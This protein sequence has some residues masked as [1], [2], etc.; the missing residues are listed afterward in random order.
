M[1]AFIP[2]PPTPLVGREAEVRSILELLHH[3]QIHLLT[4]CGP[5]GVGKT[6][7]ALQIAT[8]LASEFGDRVYWCD[9]AAL[10]DSS[11]VPQ[12]VA[13][14][15]GIGDQPNR[16]AINAICDFIQSRLALL[17]LDNCEHLLEACAALVAVISD[18]CPN[19]KI[20]TT[21]LQPLDLPQE[22]VWQVPPLTLPATNAD[23]ATIG[24][25]DA[26]RLF[27]ERAR[28]VLPTFTLDEHNAPVIAA[29]CRRLDGLPLAIE[30]AAARVK[31]LSPAQI[32]ERLDDAF[33]LLT[34]GKT[35]ALPRHQTL[36]ATMDWSYALLTPDE[37]VLTRRLSVFAGSFTVEMVEAIN[38]DESIRIPLLDVL[39][40]LVDKSLVAIYARD[41]QGVVRFRML[42]TIRQYA[43]EKLEASGETAAVR[44]RLLEWAV[45]FAEALQPQLTGREASA[46]LARL[47]MDEDN[48]R[49]A[50]QWA[51]LKRDAERGLRLATALWVYW[52]NRGAL[53]E[54][55]HWLDE[56][57]AMETPTPVLPMVRA[58][59]L[60]AAGR[61]AFRQS[62]L[63]RAHE[64]SEASLKAAHAANDPVSLAAA[65][66]LL[67]I[68][69]TERGDVSRAV[70]MHE[71]A[72]AIHRQLNDPNRAA[73]TLINLGILERRRGE[74]QRAAALYE[75]ALTI[76][77]QFGDQSLTAL[78]LLNLGETAVWQ[79]EYARAALWLEE[80]LHLYRQLENRTQ[81]ATALLN[82]SAVARYQGER[83]RARAF[84]EEAI[85][86]HQAVGDPIRVN[87]ARINLGDL[88]RDEGDWVR[89]QSLYADA[90]AHLRPVGDAW[91]IALALYSLG[92][93]ASHQHDEVQARKYYLES[94]QLYHRVGFLI[95]IGMIEVLEALCELD[96]RQGDYRRA[97]RG[98]GVAAAQRARSGAPIP[99]TE[100]ARDEQMREAIRAAL[101][102]RTDAAIQAEA[103]TLTV[104]QV[105]MEIVGAEQPK[106][107]PVATPEPVVKIYALGATRVVVGDR[108]LQ[109]TDWKYTKAR[110]LFFYLLCNPPA[111]KA[112]IGLE[113]W[114]DASP[115][116]VRNYFH[117]ALHYV[118]KA[119]GRPDWI[120]FTG[121]TYTF[122]HNLPHWC[123]IVAYDARLAEAQALLQSGLPPPAQ[124]ARALQLL[125]EAVQL[126][127]GD[128]LAD[129]DAGEWAI[130]RRE[131][132]HQSLLQALL[133][134]GRL[135]LAEA[136]YAEAARSF[137]RALTFDNYL[138]IAHRELMRTYAR[139]GDVAR[140]MRHFD[141]VRRMMRAEFGADPSAETFLLYD[142]LRRGDDV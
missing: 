115:K 77:R 18:T 32:A 104:E 79:G 68:L 107:T 4:L 48:L 96:A 59:A 101:G 127:H 37:Q 46:A 142:R 40:G 126:Q 20:L 133:D 132:L 42:E 121:D 92:L 49:A 39:T 11:Y 66:N 95:G 135:Y 76:K 138:E 65:L 61:L 12:A 122:N 110:E 16:S 116:Q 73:N 139:M 41:E 85:A 84:I 55:R 24:Q 90:L 47:A 62:D 74:L 137:Q 112:Q 67:A 91:S 119:L 6:R 93:V 103:R 53:T 58:Q 31:M 28:E 136:R 26:V 78:T 82:L 57:L 33:N 9:L 35:D 99:P 72:L 98:L 125:E 36:R 56:F 17:V 100:R 44:T 38:A 2:T 117:R 21:S 105:V 15:M 108:V 129:L 88:A 30:L 75:E 114:P 10:S 111:T 71:Q 102:Q 141:E 87:V 13:Q 97:A 134:M 25:C 80:S 54:G 69:A 29:L 123:D 130:F 120:V 94:L 124:R 70:T 1:T 140:A 7:L 34:R 27:V 3:P 23:Q 128:F 83:A 22:H 43:R 52:L 109:P 50:L 19:A 63:A 64:L 118:R 131:Q 51:R 8:A 89:A 60:H 14:A 45:A 86:L 81:I 106:M 113:L 5:G